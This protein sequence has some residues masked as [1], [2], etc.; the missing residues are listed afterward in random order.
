MQQPSLRLLLGLLFVPRFTTAH[1]LRLLVLSDVHDSLAGVKRAHQWLM[2]QGRSVDFVLCPGDF[3][4]MDTKRHGEAEYVLRHEQL[5]QSLLREMEAIADVVWVPG[6]HDPLSAFGEAKSQRE[7]F[8]GRS[9]HG[10]AVKLAPDLFAAGLGGSVEARQ[11]GDVVWE[12]FPLP[13]SGLKPHVD[14]LVAET[15]SLGPKSLILMTH[16][17]PTGVST[18]EVRG[19][20]PNSL[21]TPGV[22]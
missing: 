8:M 16:N 18:T 13:D 3:T 7:G 2:N 5:M 4:T 10:E 19:V 17:G 1:Q 21:Y 22:P 14:K 11:K 12:H 6:N 20:D 9:C 15:A